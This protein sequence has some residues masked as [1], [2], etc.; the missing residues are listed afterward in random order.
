MADKTSFIFVAHQGKKRANAPANESKRI[1]SELQRRTWQERRL[2]SAQRLRESATVP[3]TV[4]T[5]SR[6]C[7]HAGL[8]DNQPNE[9]ASRL[10][11]KTIVCPLCGQRIDVRAAPSVQSLVDDGNLDPFDSSVVT[12]TKHMQKVLRIAVKDVVGKY[13]PPADPD[14][15]QSLRSI[16]LNLD[17]KAALFS[18]LAIGSFFEDPL[19]APSRAEFIRPGDTSNSSR[20][21]LLKQRSISEINE[22]LSKPGGGLSFPIV[23]AITQLTASTFMA[24]NLEEVIIH[25]SGLGKMFRHQVPP[26]NICTPHLY[27]DIF[28]MSLFTCT[29]LDI[30]PLMPPPPLV[31]PPKPPTASWLTY[32]SM[33]AHPPSSPWPPPSTASQLNPSL[34]SSLRSL[35]LYMSF[36]DL[37]LNTTT[38]DPIR[39]AQLP[40]E[41]FL[42]PQTLYYVYAAELLHWMCD[43][44]VWASWSGLEKC[45]ARAIGVWQQSN[46][47]ALGNPV[48]KLQVG[49]LMQCMQ[50]HLAME[51][52]T[53]E[54]GVSIEYQDAVLF[55]LLVGADASER[56]GPFWPFFLGEMN[57]IWGDVGR[58]RWDSWAYLERVADGW[59]WMNREK[60]ESFRGI[61]EEVMGL[62]MG[63]VSE[64][65]SGAGSEGTV[66]GSRTLSREETGSTSLSGTIS[67]SGGTLS[68]GEGE[69]A[70]R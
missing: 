15:P 6:A 25:T 31:P 29:C 37:W 48:V 43:P 34:L 33:I 62:G 4:T 60:R 58:G 55:L 2:K 27:R 41:E 68:A 39:A 51:A 35:R 64:M 32:L 28:V 20:Y 46:D 3:T 13:R 21:L 65:G 9:S 30:P 26:E 24:G 38:L 7:R 16:R 22:A 53:E 54:F 10:R 11:A 18:T 49:R 1:R 57:R 40:P 50:M 23:F 56:D 44:V 52:L 5:V 66:E 47:Q 67:G 59:T 42:H 14:S 8:T 69:V 36:Q 63:R 12:M 19:S 70:M 45:V 61:W 17:N